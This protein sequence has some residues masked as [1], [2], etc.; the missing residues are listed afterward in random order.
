MNNEFMYDQFSKVYDRFVNWEERLSHELPFLVS[1]LGNVNHASNQTATILDAACGTGHHIIALKDN[2][3]D[4][5]GAD[6]SSNMVEIA[7]HNANK[8]GFTIP[9]KQ[10]EFGKLSETFGDKRFDGLL[11]L[12]N[13]LPHC[14]DDEALSETLSD[15]RTV[16]R[17]GGKL[18]IQNRNFDQVIKMKNRWMGPQSYQE[19]GKSWIF[20]RFY[21]FDPDGLITFNILI[22]S[23]QGEEDYQQRVIST[24]LQPLLKY[25]LIRALEI[26]GFVDLELYGD[27]QGSAFD[28]EKSG[29]LVITAQAAD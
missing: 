8:S 17:P 14:L 25:E 12:G 18:I 20:I 26:T 9:F 1:K 13:S 24:R 6:I 28:K 15:F 19:R 29:N 4:V 16:M 11:C 27:L 7:Q 10:A 3:F 21:D 5:I 23:K 22:L 2:G